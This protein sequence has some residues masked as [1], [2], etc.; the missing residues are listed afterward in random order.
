MQVEDVGRVL[1][2]RLGQCRCQAHE[3]RV[4]HQI[5]RAF[6]H[7]DFA[8]IGHRTGQIIKPG[9]VGLLAQLSQVGRPGRGDRHAPVFLCFALD[10]ERP[11]EEIAGDLGDFQITLAETQRAIDLSDRRQRRIDGYVVVLE[12]VGTLNFRLREFDFIERNHQPQIERTVAGGAHILG[13]V[14]DALANRAGFDELEEFGRRPL[15]T[16]LDVQRR[17][18]LVEVRDFHPRI[19]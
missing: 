16:T 10:L 18:F 3:I 5:R 4:D 7:P 2:K 12:L 13:E 15:G 19:R 11:A 17:D 14:I 1:A 9:R 8:A 6:I